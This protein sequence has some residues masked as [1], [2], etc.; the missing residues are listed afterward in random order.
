MLLKLLDLIAL[1]DDDLI[2]LVDLLQVL[3]LLVI[4]KK[5]RTFKLCVKLSNF[6]VDAKQYFLLSHNLDRLDRI[7]VFLAMGRKTGTIVGRLSTIFLA[8][9][10]LVLA[11]NLALIFELRPLILSQRLVFF[12]SN[13]EAEIWRFVRVIS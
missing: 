9:N 13:S 2:F 12:L 1:Y 3:D 10:T 5:K 4:R 7:Y 11:S 8:W 6:L